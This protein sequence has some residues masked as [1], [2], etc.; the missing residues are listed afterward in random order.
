VEVDARRRRRR[1]RRV[2]SRVA[3]LTSGKRGLRWAK[4][5][6]PRT[7]MKDLVLAEEPFG[8]LVHQAPFIT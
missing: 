5:F 1:R 8:Q 4:W 7:A 6:Q 3:I 2:L